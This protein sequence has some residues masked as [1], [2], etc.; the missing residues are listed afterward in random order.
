MTFILTLYPGGQEIHR[1]V[2]DDPENAPAILALGLREVRH[3][4]MTPNVRNCFLWGIG[5]DVTR[6]RSYGNLT[7]SVLEAE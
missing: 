7:L 3:D 2:V 1:W 6:R 4:E 5:R